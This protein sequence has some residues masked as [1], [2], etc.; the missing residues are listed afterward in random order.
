MD[1]HF[2]N[3]FIFGVVYVHLKEISV[4]FVTVCYKGFQLLQN[5]QLRLYVVWTIHGPLWLKF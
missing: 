4:C 3:D 5:V 1:V 2:K